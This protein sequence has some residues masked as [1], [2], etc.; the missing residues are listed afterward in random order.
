M[1]TTPH[2]AKKVSAPANQIIGVNTNWCLHGC[3]ALIYDSHGSKRMMKVPEWKE[4][5]VISTIVKEGSIFA[6]TESGSIL[7]FSLAKQPKKQQPANLVLDWQKSCQF[8]SSVLNNQ[9]TILCGTGDR[10]LS[11]VFGGIRV[12]S[13][14]GQ[15]VETWKQEKVMKSV[16]SDEDRVVA[17]SDDDDVIV[18]CMRNGHLED[19]FEFRVKSSSIL[20]ASVSVK[21]EIVGVL[22]AD[23]HV[24]L[25]SL[26]DGSFLRTLDMDDTVDI[27]CVTPTS[28][29]LT[30]SSKSFVLRHCDQLGT[31]I[32]ETELS[33]EP[34]C[35]RVAED[36]RSVVIEGERGVEVRD[37]RE[38]KVLQGCCCLV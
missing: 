36:S 3:V 4:L 28:S 9:T 26:F 7:H 12:L 15:I 8:C 37:L 34:S 14:D 5:G 18:G 11:C 20:C 6:V 33:F 30:Y 19:E 21:S 23:H 17:V 38:L 31:K 32:C 10:L 29:V 27:F 16:V 22:G 35:L 2:R 24:H 25:F 1:C 13:L